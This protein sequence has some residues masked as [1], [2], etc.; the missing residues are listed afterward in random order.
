MAKRRSQG[1]ADGVNRI[2][3]FVFI[4]NCGFLN[5]NLPLLNNC[6]LKLSFDRVNMEVAMLEAGDVAVTS[7]QTGAPLTIKDCEAITEYIMCDKLETYFMNIDDGPI[8]YYYQ[9]CDITLK[10][11]PKDETSIR[12]DNIKGGRIPVCLFAGIIPSSHLAGDIKQSSTGFNSHYVTEFNISLNGN[13]VNGYP[14][15]NKYESAIYPFYKFMDATYRYMNPDTG[16]GLKI[17]QFDYN[18]I[19][20][21]RF[22]GENSDQGWLGIN[23][24]L[25]EALAEPHSLVIWCVYNCALT[26]DKFHQIEKLSL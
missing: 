13:S 3:E 14:L 21:H 22:E 26:I 23:M 19:Y 15:Y 18:W 2:Y 4:P 17:G 10:A 25:S 16:E 24:K 1:H 7:N 8:R 11:L 6:E 9:E 20:A 5:S 12:L